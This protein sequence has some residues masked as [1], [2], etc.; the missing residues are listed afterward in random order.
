MASTHRSRTRGQPPPLLRLALQPAAAVAL[1]GLPVL[2]WSAGI[3]FVVGSY[4][5]GACTL[6]VAGVWL[7]SLALS[8]RRLQRRLG[9]PL[10]HLAGALDR[11]DLRASHRPL[12]KQ[13]TAETMR[14]AKAVDRLCERAHDVAVR[15]DAVLAASRDGV[16][17]I[18]HTGI[19]QSA[20][21]AALQMFGWSGDLIGQPIARLMTGEQSDRFAA[22]LAHYLLTGS[23]RAVGAT[24]EH[25]ALRADGSTLPVTVYVQRV[26]RGAAPP[27]FTGI[28]RA[29]EPARR[30]PGS[31]LQ[32]TSIEQAD[33]QLA[34]ARFEA[35]DARARAEAANR[36]KSE[37][38]ANMSHEIRTPMT[39]ILG[40][41]E[42]LR[43]PGQSEAERQ[44]AIETI[45]RNGG[46]LMVLIND[47]LDLSKIEAGQLALER[48]P[49][50]PIELVA[51][52]AAL[53]RARW[54]PKHL[55]IDVR[56]ECPLP[57]TISSDAARVRQ[58]LINLC[59]YAIECTGSGSVTLTL[60]LRAGTAGR[61]ARVEFEVRDTGIGI[62][63]EQIGHLFEPF[64]QADASTT[65]CF[66]GTGLG[67]GLSRRLVEL[68]GGTIAVA[69]EPG[70][71][72]VFTFTVDP[73][74]LDGV[75][76]VQGATEATAAR[77]QQREPSPTLHRLRGRILLAEDGPDNRLLITQL[78]EKA[79]AQVTVVGD[80]RSAVAQA[81][82][83]EAGGEPFDLVL[84]DMQM[85]VMDGYQAT[86]ELRR[87]GFRK[88]IVALTAN[89]LH[90]DQE[91]CLGAGC[92][93]FT[94]KPVE[95]RALFDTLAQLLPAGPTE[96]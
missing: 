63:D 58:V 55:R 86:S 64:A 42:S 45:L 79:G 46:Q 11:L 23:R 65:R 24:H 95:R 88:P 30:E 26:D 9:V 48:V 14:L 18:D 67:L 20:S 93:A 75:P 7:E 81:V 31:L 78:L 36:S 76:M 4:E 43:D 70:A 87:N 33:L 44:Q 59:G 2:V 69:S 27:L 51:E 6:A 32:S 82:A 10:E 13:A 17:T 92:T 62:A 84:M 38:L 34:Q 74:P 77:G 60:R 1:L 56:C 96:A 47:I 73:G 57:A 3:H 40:F 12:D 90:G 8:R 68:L 50:S 15:A 16:L 83:A 72:S 61:G 41:A 21:P 52:V 39:A 25:I 80:G 85:P 37:F 89:A 28:V 94:P 53:L 22:Q 35:D 54:A 91:R 5:A 66:G 49:F 29:S 71:G 19:V